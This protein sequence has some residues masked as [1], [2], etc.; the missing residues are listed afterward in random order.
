MITGFLETIF[1][2]KHPTC[3]WLTGSQ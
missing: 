3:N 2:A 1:L